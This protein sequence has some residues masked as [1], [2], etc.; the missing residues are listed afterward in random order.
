[1]IHG[2][3]DAPN[4]DVLVDDQIVLTDVPY[5]AASG[6]MN[7]PTDGFDVKVNT[8][9]TDTTA[10]SMMNVV[11]V[12]D[13]LFI[14]IAVNVLGSIEAILLDDS[15][16]DPA[17]GNLLVRVVR[18]S[19]TATAIDVYV[20]APDTDLLM[21]VPVVENAVYQDS[22]GFLE[23]PAGDCRIRVI[24]T[25]YQTIIFDSGTISLTAGAQLA[26]VGRPSENQISSIDLIAL[27]GDAAN[28]VIELNDNRTQL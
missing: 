6:Y 20:T 28:P 8:T 11:L 18:T 14:V 17:G 22:S 3:Q 2:S 9:G 19:D 13:T 25:G 5:Q 12:A 10:L 27:T 21:A 26:V 23:V 1:M 4:V 7:V 15:T 24:P 16:L